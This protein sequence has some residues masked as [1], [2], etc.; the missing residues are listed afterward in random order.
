M[1]HHYSHFFHSA[2]SSDCFNIA[3]FKLLIDFF[4]QYRIISL[5]R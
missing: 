1:R 5:K 2:T 3:S 4:L